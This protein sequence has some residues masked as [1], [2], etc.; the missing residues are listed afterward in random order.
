MLAID[1]VY[2]LPGLLGA[3][4]MFVTL[5]GVVDARYRSAMASKSEVENWRNEFGAL[6]RHSYGVTCG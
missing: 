5:A 2:G 1:Q 3:G 4:L 6:H